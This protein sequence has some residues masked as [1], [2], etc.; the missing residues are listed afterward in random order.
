M[1]TDWQKLDNLV[2]REER[3]EKE[4]QPYLE[5]IAHVL[6]DESSVA[7]D[8]ITCGREDM[9]A[10]GYADF[11]V[12]IKIQDVGSDYTPKAFVW[13][14]KAPQCYIL[15]AEKS[16]SRLH[17]TM[18]L[19]K[20]EGQLCHY[21]SS[22]AGEMSFRTRYRLE[23]CSEVVPAGIIIGRDDRLVKPAERTK[24]LEELKQMYRTSMAIRQRYI[25]GQAGIKI[26]TWDWVVAK[27]KQASHAASAAGR[28]GDAPLIAGSSPAT[29]GRARA[30]K[31]DA[32]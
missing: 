7:E 22:M 10:F 25:Y 28:F 23:T 15:Q 9:N 24:S 20:A 19:I 30:G 32:E 2:R 16:S 3:V 5:K 18:D 11:V 12:S 4:C 31:P 27:L 17:P 8:V 6:C 26:R 29:D 14:V 1:T 21:V 13:E